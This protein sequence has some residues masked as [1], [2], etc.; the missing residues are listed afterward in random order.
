MATPRWRAGCYPKGAALATLAANVG[1]SGRSISRTEMRS[2]QS[3]AGRRPWAGFTIAPRGRRHRSSR[4][5]TRRSWRESGHRAR[6]HGCH[7]SATDQTAA[8]SNSDASRRISA[9]SAYV[10]P[11]TPLRRTANSRLIIRRC[12]S[13]YDYQQRN[14]RALSIYSIARHRTHRSR[15]SR[16]VHGTNFERVRRQNFMMSPNEQ[17]ALTP[18]PLAGLGDGMLQP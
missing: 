3:A 10:R 11:A 14:R 6:F 12:G 7:C 17:F 18:I 16:F 2:G 15:T 9:D 5:S 8:L 1:K 13:D 4:R